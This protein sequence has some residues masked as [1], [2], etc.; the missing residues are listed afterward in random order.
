MAQTTRDALAP[1]DGDALRVAHQGLWILGVGLGGFLL[2][3][4]LAP[5]DQGVAAAGSVA[6]AGEKKVVQSLLTGSTA[7]RSLTTR[8]VGSRAWSRV[9]AAN[10]P[11]VEPSSTNTTSHGRPI[12]P[13]AAASSSNSR[14]T[15]RSSSRTG[16]TTEITKRAYPARGIALRSWPS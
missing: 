14:S 7:R 3:A 15:L 5:L 8:T 6:V 9:S 13:S 11:S 4:S 1:P 12:R 16:T 2:W 10:V